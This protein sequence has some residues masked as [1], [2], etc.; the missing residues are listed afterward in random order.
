MRGFLPVL[1]N[2]NETLAEKAK[3][4]PESVDIE[5]LEQEDEPH[6]ELTLALGVTDEETPD[7]DAPEVPVEC[8]QVS[9]TEEDESRQGMSSGSPVSPQNLIEEIPAA[10][11]ATNL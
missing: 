1:K 11:P 9:A 2:S 3:E 4:S 10:K 6:I 8:E 5:H 7:E